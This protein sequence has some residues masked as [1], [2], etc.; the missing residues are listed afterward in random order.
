MDRENERV[1]ALLRQFRP[2]APRA[3]PRIAAP[4][5]RYIA[6]AGVAAAAAAAV[7]AGNLR[8]MPM[9]GLTPDVIV[10][11][12]LTLKDTRKLLDADAATLDRVLMDA[13]RQLLP[14][15][16]AP[17]SALGRLSQP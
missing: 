15:V 5:P 11:S 17:E 14:D 3:L 6:W 10:G 13:S 7:M 1:E 8:F 4:R 2:R 12:G 9:A 16:E